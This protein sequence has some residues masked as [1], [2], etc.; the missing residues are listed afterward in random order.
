M[1]INAKIIADSKAENGTR[2][3]TF[4]LEFPRFILA[5]FNTHRMLSRNAAS[6]RAIPVNKILEMVWKNPACPVHWGKNQSGMQAK[7]QLEGQKLKV[8]KFLWKTSGKI[9]C[10]FAWLL[11][12]LGGHKQWVNRILEPWMYVKVVATAT[13][14]DNFFHLR[15]HPDAQPEFYE[16]A[17]RMWLEYKTSNPKL[18]KVGEWHLP[19]VNEEYKV[20][21]EDDFVPFSKN[22]IHIED[23]LKL[24]ASLCAQVSYRKSDQSIEKA[25]KI[26]DRLV[27]SKPVHCFDQNT[28][29]L[30]NLG[31]KKYDEID[32]NSQVATF[33]PED[34]CFSGFE[35][36]EEIIKEDYNG[37]VYT[38]NQKDLSMVVTPNHRI[39][40]KR[41]SRYTDRKMTD[42]SF[43]E[44]ITKNSKKCRYG[45]YGE[46]AF[47]IPTSANTN[48][49]IANTE[50]F[51]KGSLVGFFIGDGH[52]PR[53]YENIINFHLKKKRKID[54]LIN[55]LKNLNVDYKFKENRDKTVTIKTNVD[56]IFY[57]RD[58]YTD[59][60]EKTLLKNGSMDFKDLGDIEYING[61]YNG[62]INSDGSKKRNTYTYST[63]SEILKNQL[64][65]FF[66]L[67]GFGSVSVRES[68]SGNYSLMIKTRKYALV[69]DSRKKEDRV[70]IQKY[71]G[72]IHCV[73]T[74]TGLI[75]ARRNG[76]TFL[77]GNSSP[78]EHQATPFKYNITESGN[79][80]G[81][82]QYRQMIPGNVCKHY[83]PHTK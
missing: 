72:K 22:E 33:N 54:F 38:Y 52:L 17:K 4:E 64:E 44:P 23:A 65:I 9:A 69:N 48:H 63:S 27:E 34:L 36:P 10:G 19:Y 32:N 47:K 79:F 83:E 59:S 6:S 37:D 67:Y 43:F 58:F 45:T 18:L 24:S 11:N 14:W 61:I 62:L 60:R 30:T 5:E 29:I 26:Y 28:E 7:S 53:D 73:A 42:Y 35:K 51:W 56:G 12:K 31:F 80:R 2:I 20:D 49:K 40:G 55:I 66:P 16:L 39:F 41:I 46:S 8:A 78:F 21:Y 68:D 70:M 82:K 71:N 81:W 25:L 76:H 77:S 74:T 57:P 50:N 1:S 75:M 13:D 3:T 15:N